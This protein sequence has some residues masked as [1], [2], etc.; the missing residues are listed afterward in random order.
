M[1]TRALS[2]CL[3]VGLLLTC[4]FVE[5]LTQQMREFPVKVA[6]A[7]DVV[8]RTG[9]GW[10]RGEAGGQTLL[11]NHVNGAVSLQMTFMANPSQSVLPKEKLEARVLDTAKGFLSSAVEKKLEPVTLK[12]N[13]GLACYVT[14]T[15]ARLVD[16]GTPAKGDYRYMNTGIRVTEKY[17]MVFTILT[18]VKT[19]DDILSAFQIVGEGVVAK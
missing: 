1:K 11:L 13:S 17:I 5:A 14:L 3:M 15:D 10:S 8:V 18:N 16:V 2:L 19:G 9:A 6:G 4:S 12:T 7:G